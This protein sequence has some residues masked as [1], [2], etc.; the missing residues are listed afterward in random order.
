[1]SPL[2]W[3]QLSLPLSLSV[4]ICFCMLRIDIS[5]IYIYIYIK[6][7]TEGKLYMHMDEYSVFSFP[8]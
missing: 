6:E 3:Y 2:I 4:P 8:I 5:H 1:M 7:S